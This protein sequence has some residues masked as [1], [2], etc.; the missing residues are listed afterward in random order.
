MEVKRRRS[1]EMK[2]RSWLLELDREDG[3]ADERT[4]RPRLARHRQGKRLPA[5]ELR[6]RSEAFELG[7]GTCLGEPEE[8]PPALL[9]PPR[10]LAED[11]RRSCDRKLAF[12]SKSKA[13]RELKA[14]RRRSRSW[15]ACSVYKCRHCRA[16]HIG[17]APAWALLRA[18][19]P[20][21]SPAVGPAEAELV[22]AGAA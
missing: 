4:F 3:D 12:P 10:T 11:R 1:V 21:R 22:M 16:F 5:C 20:D 9:G 17:H 18:G 15:V 7:L 14:R 6:G 19:Q 13:K 8:A 2:G